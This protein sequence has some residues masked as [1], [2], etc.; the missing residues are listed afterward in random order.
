MSN[1]RLTCTLYFA[2][3]KPNTEEIISSS[4]LRK[5]LEIWQTDKGGNKFDALKRCCL[6]AILSKVTQNW[7]G[8]TCSVFPWKYFLNLTL[9]SATLGHST[10]RCGNYSREETIQGRKVFADIQYLVCSRRQN[11]RGY[12]HFCLIFKN[13]IADWVNQSYEIT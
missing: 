1:A 10:Y 7:L 2:I 12:F 13:P 9:C 5:Y 8:C 3:H 4:I 6:T 11:I